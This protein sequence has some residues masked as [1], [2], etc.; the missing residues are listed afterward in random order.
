MVPLEPPPNQRIVCQRDRMLFWD[1]LKMCPE[2]LAQLFVLLMKLRTECDVALSC[3]LYEHLPMSKPCFEQMSAAL[4]TIPL[5][6][7]T[8]LPRRT[9]KQ[10]STTWGVDSIM[11][12]AGE[13]A[14]NPMK[15]TCKWRGSE[16][17][18]FA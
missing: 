9:A 11:R 1:Y 18:D 6:P 12:P 17:D 5:R 14:E 7:M 15:T 16:F 13:S 2:K 3:R 10:V 8:L 4:S